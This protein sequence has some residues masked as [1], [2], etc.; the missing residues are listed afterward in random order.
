MNFALASRLEDLWLNDNSIASLDDIEIKLAG[1]KNSLTTVYLERN[2][3]VRTSNLKPLSIRVVIIMS[4]GLESEQT[5][6]VGACQFPTPHSNSS[7][8][9]NSNTPCY[10]SNDKSNNTDLLGI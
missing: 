3:C 7:Q 4:C 6:K 1:C 2:P 5:F 8:Q 9:S 10:I